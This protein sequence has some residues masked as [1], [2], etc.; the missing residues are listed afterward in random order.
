MSQ[1][2]IIKKEGAIPTYAYKYSGE[3]ITDPSIL[4]YIQ[5]LVIPPAYKNVEIY[6]I[7]E[8]KQP[9]LLYTGYDSKDRK[10]YIYSKHHVEKSTK[11]KFCALMKFTAMYPTIFNGITAILSDAKQTPPFDEKFETAL[12]IYIIDRCGFRLGLDKYT[13]TYKSYGVSTLLKKH[14]TMMDDSKLIF[15]FIGKK[16]VV[17]KCMVSDKLLHAIMD[18]LLNYVKVD[19][20]K[21]FTVKAVDVNNWLKEFNPSFTT[22]MFR[23]YRVNIKLI[24]SLITEEANL[25]TLA[26]RKKY[27][28]NVIESIASEFHHTVTICKKSYIYAPIIDMYLEYGRKM[29]ELKKESPPDIFIKLLQAKCKSAITSES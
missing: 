6:Y 2:I 15:E 25:P 18:K 8:N 13:D 5:K 29:K 28:K 23:T 26:K 22:K 21:I 9:N 1:K 20:A 24:E 11:N 16:G 3:T 17:N 19:S 27:L 10:Q 4:N 14:I 12:I 7:S